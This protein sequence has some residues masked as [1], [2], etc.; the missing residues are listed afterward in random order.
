M[1]EAVKPI[2]AAHGATVLV[3]DVD[4]DAALEAAYGELV[5][6]LFAGDPGEAR[7]LCHFRIDRTRVDAAV[8]TPRGRPPIEV[9]SLAKIR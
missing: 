7:E 9:A 8:R 5:P 4:T 6:V 3:V 2:A 1:L